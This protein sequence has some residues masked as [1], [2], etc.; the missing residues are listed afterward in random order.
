MEQL[1]PKK[2]DRTETINRRNK[3]IISLYLKHKDKRKHGKQIYSN[4]Y[5]IAFVA[6]KFYL[7]PSTIE[8]IIFHRKS[9]Q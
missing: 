6:H 9:K 7:S 5:I 2:Y 8:D 1:A 4:E 3:D